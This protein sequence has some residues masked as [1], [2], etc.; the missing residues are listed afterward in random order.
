MRNLL[1]GRKE[2]AENLILRGKASMQRRK[3]VID[4]VRAAKIWCLLGDLEPENARRNREC[5]WEVSEQKSGC[6][7]RSLGGYYF[8][9]G[10]FPR[11]WIVLKKLSLLT[12]FSLGLGSFLD[13]HAYKRKSGRRRVMLSRNSFLLTTRTTRG[14]ITWPV[15]TCERI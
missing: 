6:T 12:S 1:E 7:M 13:V 15:S 9:K 14:G 11:P 2:E 4:S 10:N 5:V 3:Q 8:T